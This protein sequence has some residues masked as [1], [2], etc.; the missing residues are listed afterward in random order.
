M[1]INYNVHVFVML[2]QCNFQ[3]W[4]IK[5]TI[6]ECLYWTKAFHSAFEITVP[7]D[8]Y[9]LYNHCHE[10]SA[11]PDINTGC[12]TLSKTYSVTAITIVIHGTAA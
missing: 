6:T 12:I 7:T 3:P 4:S 1:F 2:L 10:H 5:S 8:F 11:D 9:H